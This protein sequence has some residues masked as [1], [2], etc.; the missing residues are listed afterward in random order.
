MGK[1]IG[2]RIL[3]LLL[4]L[5][6]FVSTVF[7][8]SRSVYAD[9]N[10]IISTYISMAAGADT[11]DD[12][13][14]IDE[15]SADQ[16]R[17]LGVFVS[18]FFVPFTTE[19]GTAAG[20]ETDEVMDQVSDA[21]ST[22]LSFSEAY[23]QEF[24]DQIMGLARASAT[25]LIFA[26]STEYQKDYYV[27]ETFKPEANYYNFLN[28]MIG[29]GDRALGYFD[30]QVSDN[31]SGMVT[32]TIN[33][34]G[35]TKEVNEIEANRA[36]WEYGYWGYMSG[37]EF[38]PVAD[39][40]LSR[41]NGFTAF[42]VAF[43]N[44]L[45]NSDYVDG[46]GW[47]VYDL[48]NSEVDDGDLSDSLTASEGL[49][50]SIFGMRVMVDCFGDILVCGLQHQV[51]AVPGALNP[52][53]WVA[54]DAG[55]NDVLSPGEAY[56]IINI[57]SMASADLGKGVY[58]NRSNDMDD[59]TDDLD[60][61]FSD[62]TIADKNT[63][64]GSDGS[65]VQ[66]GGTAN[67][68]G[69]YVLFNTSSQF[70]KTAKHLY[71][72]RQE[73][74]LS[75]KESYER[76]MNALAGV[77]K[78]AATSTVVDGAVGG[79]INPGGEM[80]E[81]GDFTVTLDNTG[82]T[83]TAKLNDWAHIDVDRF[84]ASNVDGEENK[85][86]LQSLYSTVTDPVGLASGAAGASE[87]LSTT[88][89]DEMQD[90]VSK[91]ID[92]AVKKIE[93]DGDSTDQETS[94]D[95]TSTV[96]LKSMTVDYGRL[97]FVEEDKYC[98]RL[99]RGMEDGTDPDSVDL[100]QL[101]KFWIFDN[102]DAMNWKLVL[103]DASLKYAEIYPY[104]FA[105]CES[106]W[107]PLK[108]NNDYD[109]IDFDTS[110]AFPSDSVYAMDGMYVIDNLAAFESADYST[111]NVINYV[112]EDG[113][114]TI[115]GGQ[116][117][118]YGSDN[119]F[120]AGYTNAIDGKMSSSY[121]NVSENALVSIYT[122]Y[123]V[124][125]LYND[126]SESRK[127]TIGRVGYRMNIDGLPS[128]PDEPLEISDELRADLTQEAIKN[129]LYYLLHPTEGLNY[130]RELITNKLNAFLVGWHN[131]MLGTT[132]VGAVTGT[133]LYRN[134]T[135][136]VTTPDLSEIEWTSSLLN[137]YNNSIP[138]LIIIMLVMMVLAYVTGVLSLQRSI[139]GLLL[140]S[141]F[142]MI[143]VNLINGVV[144]LSNRIS[145]N[146]YGEKFTYWALMQQETYA[147]SIDESAQGDS[148][149]NY[150]QNLYR[151]NNAV[152]SNQG[153]E[154]IVLKWQS[155]KKLT[156]LMVTS[157]D[158][159]SNLKD[160]GQQLLISFLS[161]K[162]S[163]ESYLDD[164][165]SVYLYR[166]YIDI[167][168]FSRYIY[169][170]IKENN[171]SSQRS[172]NNT[173]M[174]HWT[175]ELKDA[176][177]A[178][179]ENYAAD[180]NSGYANKDKGST[181]VSSGIKITVPMSSNIIN[182]A[183]ADRGTVANMTL[184]DFVGVN[185]NLFNFGIPVFNKSI[186]IKE[187]IRENTEQDSS[188]EMDELNAELDGVSEQ[189]LVGLAAYSLYSESVFYYFSWS[190]YDAG[191]QPTSLANNGYRNLL[192]G[193]NNTGYFY[194]TSGNGELKDFMDMRSLFTYIIPYLKQCNNLVHEWDET[195]GLF[196]Y[197]E[198]PTDEGHWNDEA[199]KNSQEMSQK[200]W[201]NLNVARLYSIYT[202]WVDVMYDC[203]YADA[204]TINVFG[205]KVVVQN[206]LDPASYP[207]DRPMIF[208]ESEML[209]FGLG[210][211]DLTA[212][213]RKIIQCNRGMEERMYEL[214]N[215]YNFSD[216]TLNTAAAMN[217]AFEFNT[218]F[219]ENG[220]FDNNHNIYP[221]SFELTDFSYDAFLRFILS[222]ST[223]ETM[224]STGD[225]YQKIVNNSSMTTII[226]MIILDIISVY[227]LP[228]F[229]IFFIIAI[230][231]SF[232]LTIVVTAF[233]MDPEGKYIRK[234]MTG[235]VI[236]MLQFF[237]T[238]VA[239][240]FV[241]SLFMGDG[242]TAVTQTNS[243]SIQMG[244]PTTVMVVMI[245]VNMGVLALYF[246]IIRNVLRN[247]KQNAKM[248]INFVGGVVGGAMAKAG[249]AVA[250]AGRNAVGG[251]SDGGSGGSS[252]SD[253]T[254]RESARAAVRGDNK[255]IVDREE[256]T[257]RVVVAEENQSRVNDTRRD[258]SNNN[259]YKANQ[260]ENMAKKRDLD[261][262]VKSG[263]KNIQSESSSR[264]SASDVLNDRV[265]NNSNTINELGNARKES[266][267]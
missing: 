163:G 241:I 171:V 239:F 117:W 266:R 227:V 198:A 39:F 143:P 88:D 129:F 156:S 210:E 203:S 60:S 179:D 40:K 157:D 148:Y 65:V 25:D 107:I 232:V 150:L 262:K 204:E 214:L 135:G 100:D 89:V 36:N 183:L 67:T 184:D 114:S 257:S 249:G 154:S 10:D 124:A 78:M 208:S 43:L 218:T 201:H 209:D 182:D 211:G 180:R 178:M 207:A 8:G 18:N 28:T 47:N 250:G 237:V 164:M 66:E 206:P 186:D 33:D 15:L 56:Q 234:V 38:V 142:L 77:L 247:I 70:Y 32:V 217:C 35:D 16:L 19:M 258:I 104:D 174:S 51:V 90:V 133:T 14:A 212:A 11:L 130:V 219:S 134:T 254:G 87:Q 31:G 58:D 144:G 230:F 177:Y 20:E 220:I 252:A 245:A 215:Y 151:Q 131:D 112:N 85:D 145:D 59:T 122:S 111:F 168:N 6:V 238:T 243:L 256:S 45:K 4:M 251:G 99:Y 54:V 126:T 192:I 49:Q 5:V 72:C 175:T 74:L 118:V 235:G 9:S 259:S 73:N 263:M 153:S 30:G 222:N 172:L 127:N 152:Y 61:L 161:N 13:Y 223:G 260:E 221:Q 95:G 160:E 3:C 125:C 83:V 199:I 29:G 240:S 113:N 189:D 170:G 86:L 119:T 79:A 265:R 195:Y 92:D 197:E 62:I 185:Q 128:M 93:E 236:P 37:S 132:G 224:N 264:N 46:Y 68:L 82:V 158:T 176:V 34:E 21:L 69:S 1:R 120:A 75:A 97:D 12:S 24:A 110:G 231:L 194:N 76:T 146:L 102:G 244:D 193:D 101:G 44:C 23:A 261:S 106:Q 96:K 255:N 226:V 109:R 187:T 55:G 159:Y 246:F 253:G 116:D 48:V 196:I 169:N 64:L 52:Y 229:K 225:F 139:F 149:S 137:F 7:S 121:A 181:N 26:A 140:F 57:P 242:N 267:K 71:D 147:N 2:K 17:F 80:Y 22:A 108:D 188:D 141:V 167:S 50:L 84:D 53:T 228:A 103:E 191:L 213:E 91:A 105:V 94:T 138:F 63:N 200:Y 202:P 42:Q 41:A 123:L 166:S 136:Y 173:I 27:P 98:L 81:P 248:A 190:L 115:A 155:P 216:F 205:E 233:K 162:F 165:D